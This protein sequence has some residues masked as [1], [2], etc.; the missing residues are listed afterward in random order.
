L[1]KLS[2]PSTTTCCNFD[3]REDSPLC[4]PVLAACGHRRIAIGRWSI[5][6][7]AA[8]VRPCCPEPTEVAYP[9]SLKRACRQYA[10]KGLRQQTKGA[11]RL[12]HRS[13][14]QPSSPKPVKGSS[15]PHKPRS[16]NLRSQESPLL[17]SGRARISFDFYCSSKK[18]PSEASR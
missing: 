8:A 18:L 1:L 11:D 12:R 17:P 7:Y 10:P 13:P 14:D 16:N 15:E 6:A 3:R 9:R 2:C 5:S 4:W